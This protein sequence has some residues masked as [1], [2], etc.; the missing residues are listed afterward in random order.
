MYL[1]ILI[2]YILYIDF[3]EGL[4]LYQVVKL[5]EFITHELPFEKINDA[6]QLLVDGKSLRCVLKF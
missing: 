2:N 4:T 1:N 3:Q 6:F 5:D